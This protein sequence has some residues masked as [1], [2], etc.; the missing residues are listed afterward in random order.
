MP[1]NLTPCIVMDGNARDAIHFYEKVL[2]AR[3]LH[4]QTY[5]EMPMPCPDGLKERVSNA[6][7]RIEE[8]ELMLFDAPNQHVTNGVTGG[9]K[10]E[11][12]GLAPSVNAVVALNI[13]ISDVEK[14]IR[15]FDALKDGGKVI[16]PLEKVPFSP[17][18]GTVTDKFGVTFIL[19]TQQSN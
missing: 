10:E 8:S 19:V 18:F 11:T 4:V 1:K 9:D 16:A 7:L 5:G 14:T 12:P 6:L 17:A 3:V 15:I 13:S 2:E